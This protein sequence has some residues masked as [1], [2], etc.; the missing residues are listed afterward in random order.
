MLASFVAGLAGE[1]VRQVR[2]SNPQSLDKAVNT[3]LAAQET[4]RQERTNESFHTKTDG[5]V[6]LTSPPGRAF[7]KVEPRNKMEERGHSRDRIEPTEVM[8]EG[9]SDAIIATVLGTWR[10]C[11]PRLRKEC[12]TREPPGNR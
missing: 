9:R 11:P 8:E 2:F 10:E 3:A 6:R 1:V 12:G 4:I 5:S 7:G